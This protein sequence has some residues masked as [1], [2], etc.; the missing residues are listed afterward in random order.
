MK[1]KAA[2]KATDLAVGSSE[3]WEKLE[4]RLVENNASWLA[5]AQKQ[6]MLIVKDTLAEYQSRLDLSGSKILLLEKDME[7]VLKKQDATQEE[8]KQLKDRLGSSQTC[9]TSQADHGFASDGSCSSL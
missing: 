2:A 5:Q 3:T 4:A 8:L 6:S 1:S 7:I 9:S